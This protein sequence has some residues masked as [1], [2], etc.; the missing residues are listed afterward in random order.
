MVWTQPGNFPLTLVQLTESKQTFLPYSTTV[1]TIH[2]L[3]RRQVVVYCLHVRIA[4]LITTTFCTGGPYPI[5]EYTS[6]NNA[7][8]RRFKSSGMWCCVVWCVPDVSVDHIS[9]I[10]MVKQ[11]KENSCGGKFVTL[12]REFYFYFWSN[13]CTFLDRLWEFLEVEAPRYPNN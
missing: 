3:H 8:K 5:N 6:C 2:P 11:P 10:I 7:H 12:Y 4:M 13:Q 9:F 1:T